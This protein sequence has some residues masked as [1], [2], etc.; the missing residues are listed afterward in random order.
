MNQFTHTHTHTHTHR[1]GGEDRGEILESG[2]KDG[3]REGEY[4]GLEIEYQESSL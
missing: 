1:G 4:F 3:G 2:E